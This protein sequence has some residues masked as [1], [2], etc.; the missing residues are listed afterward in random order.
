MKTQTIYLTSLLL[1]SASPVLVGDMAAPSTTDG[2]Q[3]RYGD[4]G[5][6]VKLSVNHDI[7]A[8][9]QKSMAEFRFLMDF[10][11]SEAPGAFAVDI[12][13]VQGSYTA[14]DMTQRL[15]VSGLKGQSFSL[16]KTDDDRTLRR[17]DSDSKLQINLGE[18]IGTSYSIGL[19][20]AD[21]LPVL[22][23]E[24]VSLGSTW[25]SARDTFSL[26]GWAWVEGR[27]SSEHSVTAVEQLDGH[28]IVSITSTAHAQLSD[29]EGGVDYSGD[30]ELKRTSHW[31]FDATEGRLLSVS[32]V[33]ETSGIN[34]LPQGTFDIR[35]QTK[36][37]FSTMEQ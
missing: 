20:L 16:D 24:P 1:L 22:P 29:V 33:Q 6:K 18:M 9:Q 23:E 31:R 37:E 21:I 32:M 17:T 4:P 3:L 14:H 26:E 11:L 5:S 27:L 8:G 19:A 28:T 35:Q 2:L 25:Q 12:N 13:K 36:V 15:P 10:E 30:G 7:S 34:T